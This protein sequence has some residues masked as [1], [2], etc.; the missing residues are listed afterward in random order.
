M[1]T[2]PGSAGKSF[3]ALFRDRRRF[4][5]RGF[6]CEVS[7][8]VGVTAP[9]ES[10]AAGG[11]T[12][13]PGAVV[14]GHTRDLSESGLSLVLPAAGH[15]RAGYTAAGSQLRVALGLP[16]GTISMRASTV[17]CETFD[18]GDERKHLIGA[19]IV[20]M[21]EADRRRYTEFLHGLAN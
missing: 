19:C 12:G 21:A 14:S 6:V 1:P 17:R 2:N 13:G 20:S 7:L 18:H 9:D 16:G 11:A 8:P 15:E 4:A 10:V 3:R 5:R